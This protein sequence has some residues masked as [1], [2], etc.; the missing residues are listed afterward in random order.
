MQRSLTTTVCNCNCDAVPAVL[1]FRVAMRAALPVRHLTVR[2]NAG[3]RSPAW[4]V[5][6]G[7]RVDCFSRVRLMLARAVLRGLVTLL[8]TP[9]VASSTGHALGG[10]VGGVVGGVGAGV[11]HHPAR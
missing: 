8:V 2:L 6:H 11:E 3:R 1:A 7:R 5:F 10:V 4:R 9:F